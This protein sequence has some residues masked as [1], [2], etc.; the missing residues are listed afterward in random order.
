MNTQNLNMKSMKNLGLTQ[1][2]E[3]MNVMLD[4]TKNFRSDMDILKKIDLSKLSEFSIE[5]QKDLNVEE[6]KH[7]HP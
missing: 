6:E 2:N 1:K 3:T 4:G 7:N 5:D